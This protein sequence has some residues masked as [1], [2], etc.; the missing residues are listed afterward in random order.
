ML[1]RA[2]LNGPKFFGVH[3]PL[4]K[5]VLVPQGVI[6]G[7]LQARKLLGMMALTVMTHLGHVA[8]ELGV[9]EPEKY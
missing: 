6:L 8:T 7:Y 1:C 2:G 9:D 4:T 5:D 3:L